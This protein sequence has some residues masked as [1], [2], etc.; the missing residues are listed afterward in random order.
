MLPD[1]RPDY[2]EYEG[3]ISGGRG[4]VSRWDHGTY[5]IESESAGELAIVLFGA[6]LSGRVRLTCLPGQAQRWRCDI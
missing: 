2:L 6:K 1:H 5:Q 3:P 4:T